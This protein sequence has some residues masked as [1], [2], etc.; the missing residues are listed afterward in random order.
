M[1]EISEYIKRAASRTGFKREFFVE[2]KMPTEPSNV[3]VLP[4]FGDLRST[5]ILSS[6]ILKNFKDANPDKY[7]ILCCWPGMQSFFPYVDEYWTIED[8]S[9]VKGLAT[10]ANNLYNDSNVAAELT[11]SLAEVLNIITTRDLAKYYDKGFTKKY[12]DDFGEITRFLPEV[13][14]ASFI[15]KDFKTQLTSREG[16]KI[17]V[18]PSTRMQSWQK[19]AITQLPV[20]Q[21]FWVAMINRLI[22]DGYV[23]IVYQNWFTYDMSKEFEDRCLY[24]VPRTTS[25][26]IAALREIGILLDIHTGVSRL[27]IAA[28]CPYLAATER[29]IYIENKDYELDDLCAASLPRQYIFSFS[30]QLMVG[31][32]EEWEISILSNIMKRLKEFIPEIKKED[33]PSTLGSYEPVSCLSVRT[34]KSKRLGSAF[35]R[36]SKNK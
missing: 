17:V 7:L 28:R 13:P 6:L 5:F 31:T 32:P 34:R 16:T 25:D 30:T 33:L 14:S 21:E 12:W 11:K 9:L 8:E 36:S 27:A 23:P 29:Q 35:I 18:Y 22:K 20:Q 15:S 4:F 3:Y 2:K 10:N 19:G 24:L 26:L 1:S